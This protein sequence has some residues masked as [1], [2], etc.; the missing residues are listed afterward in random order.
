MNK[1]KLFLENFFIYGFG[2]VISKI[3][4]LIMIPIVTHLM[5][6]SSYY[7]ISDMQT[8]MVQFCTYLA[9]LGMYDAM[10]RMF[11][12][13]EGLEYKKEICSTAFAFTLVTSVIVSIIMIMLR[14]QLA[15]L[16]FEDVKYEYLVYIAAL[17]TLVSG[18]NTI[19]MA[20]T[21]MQNKRKT[22]IL[23]NV[24][25]SI[26]SYSISV[27]LLLRGCYDIA[28]P[29]AALFAG[30]C[31]ET[32]FWVLNHNWFS[33]KRINGKYL[34]ELLQIGLPLVPNFIIYWIF[35]SSDKLITGNTIKHL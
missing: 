33:I 17:T 28:L 22:Y 34:K 4:P 24:I 6:N 9:I 21:R 5:P 13:R 15:L 2:S 16:F 18:T 19:L 35:N 10:Y 7:G 11:F 26:L 25:T 23:M 3:I 14:K 29:I 30:L 31:S 1:L 32:I 27:P 12:E 20:P 8:T